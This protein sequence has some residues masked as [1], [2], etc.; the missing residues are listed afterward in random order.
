MAPLIASS[1]MYKIPY[2]WLILPLL[3]LLCH[4]LGFPR[5]MLPPLVPVAGL[6]DATPEGKRV[7]VRGIV[8]QHGWRLRKEGQP[9]YYV[10][11]QDRSSPDPDDSTV[12]VF[13]P[14]PCGARKFW[15]PD[16]GEIAEASGFPRKPGADSPWPVL[17]AEEVVV[18]AP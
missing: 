7:R 13:L 8:R 14:V 18:P 6:A 3:G 10:D 17:E 11:L 15:C 4:T 5:A 16:T 1:I 9:W 2:P 12:R